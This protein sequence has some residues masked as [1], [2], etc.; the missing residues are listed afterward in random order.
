M[1]VHPRIQVPFTSETISATYRTTA[2][3]TRERPSIILAPDFFVTWNVESNAQ[4]QHLLTQVNTVT[5]Y[6]TR[7]S[8]KSARRS[9]VVHENNT[10]LLPLIP[11]GS[12]A[13]SDNSRVYSQHR[14]PTQLKTVTGLVQACTLNLAEENGASTRQL[15]KGRGEP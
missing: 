1:K 7:K 10:Q 14:T 15:F 12:R 6:A 3:A 13:Q 4:F 2:K 9:E 5:Q 8:K 11:T